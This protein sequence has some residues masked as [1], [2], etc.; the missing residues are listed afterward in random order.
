MKEIQG[1]KLY[2]TDEICKMLNCTPQTL[3]KVRRSGKLRYTKLGGRYYS[4]E[5]AIKD[6]LNGV[7]PTVKD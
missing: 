6:Y 1:I 4:S 3:C 2:S 7:V 5:E